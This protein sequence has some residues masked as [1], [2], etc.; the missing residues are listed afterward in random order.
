MVKPGNYVDSK[1]FCCYECGTEHK[2]AKMKNTTIK[3]FGGVGYA[4]EELLKKNTK[5]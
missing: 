5:Y 2:Y 1:R 4:S 3:N